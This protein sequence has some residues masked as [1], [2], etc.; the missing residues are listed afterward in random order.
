[1]AKLAWD[2]P[3][4]RP[5]ESGVDRGVLYLPTGEG[6]AWNG[7]T[8][9][10][11]DAY[12]STEPVY[13]DGVKYRDVQKIDDYAATLKAFTYPDEFLE[14]DG[15]LAVG[16]GLYVGDQRARTFGLSYRTGVGN[17]ADGD[18]YGY[19]IHIV[20][21]ITASTDTKEYATQ[22][23][24]SSAMEFSWKLN[25]V[26]PAYPGFRP[27]AHIIVDSTLINR[28][29]LSDIEDVLYGTDTTDAYLP[30]IDDLAGMA[31]TFTTIDIID[32][33][34][35]TWTAVGPDELITMTDATTFRIDE[36]NAVFIDDDTYQISTT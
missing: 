1:M 15:V 22:G 20:Y 23:E 12:E 10:E 18:D 28:F 24:E 16:E 9:V 30:P 33:G 27:T 36:V 31:A 7:L 8:A 19:K 34:D 26:P 17:D 21:N 11:E 25:A 6:V 32:N 29:L 4:E 35:G 2:Q 14:F 13:V 3:E 5:Y